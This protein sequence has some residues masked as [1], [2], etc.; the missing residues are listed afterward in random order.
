MAIWIF[1]GLLLLA[2]GAIF[3][4]QLLGRPVVKMPTVAEKQRI[5]GDLLEQALR[6]GNP[7]G[8]LDHF[9]LG[10][11]PELRK[12]STVK[13]LTDLQKQ[14]GKLI[15]MGAPLENSQTSD[16]LFVYPVDFEKGPFFIV[17]QLEQTDSEGKWRIYSFNFVRDPSREAPLV[18]EDAPPSK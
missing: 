1:L 10:P 16:T 5:C 17:V 6:D 9:S 4:I 2:G 12:Q 18:K 15:T 7:Q 11:Q 14:T 3:A 8:L 13:Y